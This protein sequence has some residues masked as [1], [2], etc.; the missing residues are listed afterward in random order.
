MNRHYAKTVHEITR[1]TETSIDFGVFSRNVVR[2]MVTSHMTRRGPFQGVRFVRGKIHD[3]EAI[4]NSIW[5]AVGKPIV[6]LKSLL[7]DAGG[8]N[9][10]RVLVEMPEPVINEIVA[11]LRRMFKRLL[12]VC[13]GVKSPGLTAASKILFSVFP[14]ISLPVE[15]LHWK[16]LFQAVDYAD[17]IWLMRAEISA[18]ESRSR[19]NLN[20]CDP[21]GSITLPVFY[22]AVALR[23]AGGETIDGAQ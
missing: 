12:P 2:F 22:N 9:R 11:D 3:P 5:D 1:S 20:K 19:K 18:W 23:A 13:R 16:N 10:S 4:L 6:K 15:N 14:E 17:L 7:L 8:Q 21:H